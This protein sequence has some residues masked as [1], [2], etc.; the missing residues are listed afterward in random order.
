V[1]TL[2]YANTH[3]H[4]FPWLWAQNGGPIVDTGVWDNWHAMVHADYQPGME[5][6]YRWYIENLVDL[7]ERLSVTT[8]ADGDNMLDT[9]LV[10]Y[11]SEFS[12]GRHWYTSL[13]VILAGN[14]GHVET[15]RFLNHMTLDR[16]TFQE[17]GGYEY[18]GV[19]TNQLYTSLLHMLGFED[20]G[21]GYTDDSA[22]PTGGLPGL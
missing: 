12:S 15:G 17:S 2:D 1:A 21:F 18:S 8:D 5:H 16:T 19:T 9:T 10:V 6:V 22:L 4:A 3:D 7:L 14:T 13:P 11:L 20:E